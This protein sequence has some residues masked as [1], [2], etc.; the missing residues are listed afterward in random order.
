MLFWFGGRFEAPIAF[1]VRLIRLFDVKAK[2][3]RGR[4]RQQQKKG[5]QSAGTGGRRNGI[6]VLMCRREAMLA[7]H[8]M[9]HGGNKC[10]LCCQLISTFGF[11]SLIKHV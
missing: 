10:V 11:E 4:K 7:S 9:S 6:G 2:T 1:H 8:D 5:K 3:E